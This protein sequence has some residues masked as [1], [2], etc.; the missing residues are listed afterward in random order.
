[1]VHS[2]LLRFRLRCCRCFGFEWFLGYV[3]GELWWVWVLCRL[4]TCWVWVGM[5]VLWGQ[6]NVLWF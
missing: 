5:D 6:G 3:V 1:M 4:C 2:Y